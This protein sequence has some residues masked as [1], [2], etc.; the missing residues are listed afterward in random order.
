MSTNKQSKKHHFSESMFCITAR[1]LFKNKAAMLGLI[2]LV[3]EVILAI[4]APYISK[5]SYDA[6]DPI[7]QFVGPCA[8]HWFGTDNLGRDMFSRVLYGGR[9]SLAIGISATLLG[10]VVGMIVGGIAGYFGGTTDLILM[11]ALDVITSIPS[12]LLTI[13]IVAVM[14]TGVVPTL[15]ALAVGGIAGAARMFRAQCLA[16][17]NQEYVEAC[18]SIGCS[19]ISILLRHITPNAISPLIVST[20]LGMAT[21]VTTCAGLSFIG[22][23]VQMPIPEWGALLS[24]GRTYLRQY[25][26][27]SIFPGLAIMITVFSLNM[28][29]DGLRDALDPKLKN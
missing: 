6:V 7:N 13:I 27:L 26:Y 5:Y 25:S 28:L 29:G 17:R 12:M 19:N 8:E 15:C 1:R 20:T 10:T 16:I 22:L 4:L 2:V 21:A 18:R 11:R 9:Y 23:G 14:G 3:V 24:A